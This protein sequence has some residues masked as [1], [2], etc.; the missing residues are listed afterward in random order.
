MRGLEMVESSNDTTLRGHMGATTTLRGCPVGASSSRA[1]PPAGAIP[2][3]RFAMRIVRGDRKRWSSGSMSVSGMS[4]V[5]S[6]VT[7]S[8]FMGRVCRPPLK[9]SWS[10][11]AAPATSSA[12][13]VRR[14]RALSGRLSTRSL[15]ATP[16]SF[17]M[18]GGC[19]YS[20]MCG[21]HRALPYLCPSPGSEWCSVSLGSAAQMPL[22]GLRSE[23]TSRGMGSLLE[24]ESSYMGGPITGARPDSAENVPCALSDI[25]PLLSLGVL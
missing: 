10:E 19:T 18:A 5:T 20:W 6:G 16:G 21:F 15:S 1:V 22:A 9:R 3:D 8:A 12:A 4:G 11:A 14:L 23:C 25:P 24:E 2:P 13:A 7:A 17:F